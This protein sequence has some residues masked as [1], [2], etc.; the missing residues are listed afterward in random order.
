MGGSQSYDPERGITR[1]D[2]DDVSN[3]EERW[4]WKNS[5][6]VIHTSFDASCLPSY[7]SAEED[8]EEE[9]ISLLVKFRNNLEQ[10]VINKDNILD[11]QWINSIDNKVPCDQ[12][13]KPIKGHWFTVSS[14]TPRQF[15]PEDGVLKGSLSFFLQKKRHI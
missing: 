1:N 4:H 2:D 7:E 3:A 13:N 9:D 10:T 12:C 6:K 8:E 15:A 5:S 14:I 11:A